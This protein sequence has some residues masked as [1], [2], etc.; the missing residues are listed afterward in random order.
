MLISIQFPLAD[1]RRFIG[2][3]TGLLSRPVWPSP[4]PDIDF[5]RY[6]GSIR[7]RMGGGLRGWGEN[8]ICEA[9]NALRF[10]ELPSF[11]VS[12]SGLIIPLR[13]AFRRFFFDGYAVGKFE[14]GI[15]TRNS[16]SLSLTKKQ[17]KNLIS[18]ILCLPV[19]IKNP[20]GNPVLCELGEARKQLGNLY[21]I[22]TTA[23]S[24]NSEIKPENWWVKP[25][26]PLLI[27]QYESRERFQ[28]PFL[29][30]VVTLADWSETKISCYKLQYKGSAIPM[31]LFPITTSSYAGKSSRIL[32][33]C[34]FR[35]HA[36]YECLHIILKN[37]LTKQ[38][39]VAP[40]SKTSDE[41][42]NYLN[43]ATKRI[44]RWESRSDK[45]SE[46]E[47]AEFARELEDFI[48]PGQRDSLLELLDILDIRVNVSNKVKDYLERSISINDSQIQYFLLSYNNIDQSN[49][50]FSM[51]E[52]GDQFINEKG[53]VGIMGHHAS[54]QEMNFNQRWNEVED[55]IDVTTLAKELP[56]LLEELK[57][58]ATEGT[59]YKAIGEVAD[60][61]K[62]AEQKDGS[63]TLEYLAKAGQWV[64]DIAKNI[65][66]PVATKALAIALGLPA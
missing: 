19:T 47:L 39:V 5:V 52:T 25:G 35:L 57:K 61:Q 38:L 17:T 64:L 50:S 40:R 22:A 63:K 30:K 56:L 6:F 26:D 37:I 29:G 28:I 16:E 21:R 45:V 10:R 43:K 14:V 33:L 1:S 20:S 41:L 58:Q 12:E 51:T 2:E 27:F 32:R 18:H 55:S 23:I 13:V 15:A 65:G 34:L 8:L 4:S 48:S 7:T 42:Q 3:N 60:A 24:H 62:A 11:E 46:A 9:D 31:W 36:E 49:R 44:K 53:Q 66:V 59:H 54:V